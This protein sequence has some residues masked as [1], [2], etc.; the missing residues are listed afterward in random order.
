ML[1]IEIHQRNN[2]HESRLHSP[3]SIGNFYGIQ[4]VKF[5]VKPVSRVLVCVWEKTRQKI[6]YSNISELAESTTGNCWIGRSFCE[7][8]FHG[9]RYFTEI[10][11]WKLQARD[12]NYFPDLRAPNYHNTKQLTDNERREATVLQCDLFKAL[13]ISLNARAIKVVDRKKSFAFQLSNSLFSTS[14]IFFIYPRISRH[15]ILANNGSN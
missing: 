7:A 8:I 11:L 2:M 4:I 14:S 10:K 13:K 15:L 5:C 3:C 9:N 6:A 1:S 12:L